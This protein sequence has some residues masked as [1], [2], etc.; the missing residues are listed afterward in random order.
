MQRYLPATLA[1]PRP[2]FF[3]TALGITTSLD[4]PPAFGAGTAPPSSR[5]NGMRHHAC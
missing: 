2:A 1:T 4:P 3:D 5:R